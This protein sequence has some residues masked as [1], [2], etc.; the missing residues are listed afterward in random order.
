MKILLRL[1]IYLLNYT[2]P[3]LD[4]NKDLLKLLLNSSCKFY[5]SLRINLLAPELFF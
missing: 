4:Y 5:Y 3:N 2:K 1:E